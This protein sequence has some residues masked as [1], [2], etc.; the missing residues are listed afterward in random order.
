VVADSVTLI[1]SLP[2]EI[3]NLPTYAGAASASAQDAAAAKVLMAGPAATAILRENAWNGPPD[4]RFGPS[5]CLTG[6][7]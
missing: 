3:R 5:H 7:A 6:R 4:I 1:G 2:A